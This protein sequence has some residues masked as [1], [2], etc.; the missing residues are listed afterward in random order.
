MPVAARIMREA[1]RREALPAHARWFLAADAMHAWYAMLRRGLEGPLGGRAEAERAISEVAGR[2]YTRRWTILRERYP[3]LPNAPARILGALSFT[4][5]RP[6]GAW[7]F[8]SI[9]T[10]PT[11]KRDLF[12]LE[13]ELRSMPIEERW[14]EVTTHLGEV[15][16]ELT[17]SLPKSNAVLGQIC[18][19][20]GRHVGEQAKR[21][22]AL[23]DTPESAIEVLRMSEYVFRVNPEHWH[24]VSREDV[25]AA[26]HTGMLE[27]TACPWFT[28]PG[29]SMMH[30]GIF[31]QFQSGI[32]SVFGL[33]YQ[34]TQTIPKHGGS[35]CRIDL[36]PTTTNVLSTAS[37]TRKTSAVSQSEQSTDRTKR[38]SERSSEPTAGGF[39]GRS[40]PKN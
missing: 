19:E 40:P 33:R 21:M 18:F 20:G 31:G 27:G 36:K 1:Y 22:F 12:M 7:V 4:S 17:R 35:T 11:R 10:P 26:A 38:V 25:D 23:P 9:G 34:L 24:T 6:R 39:G 15:L 2:A 5:L 29:W 14:R 16:I 30:C 13:R 32:S 28:A 8:R 3:A 37:L